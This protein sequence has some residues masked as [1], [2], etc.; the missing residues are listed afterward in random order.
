V[1]AC[2]GVYVVMPSNLSPLLLFFYLKKHE[3]L[4]KKPLGIGGYM[5]IQPFHSTKASLC[6]KKDSSD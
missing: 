3:K 2:V 6:G 5:K 4:F 1:G